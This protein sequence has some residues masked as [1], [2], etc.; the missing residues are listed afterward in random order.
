MAH[1]IGIAS[2]KGGAGKT[3]LTMGLAGAALAAGQR[4]VVLDLDPQ[5]SL[6]EWSDLRG[7]ETPVVA[8]IPVARLPKEL[9]TAHRMADLILIDTPPHSEATTMAVAKAADLILIPC[10]PG[11]LDILSIR[12]TT[13]MIVAAGKRGNIVFNGCRPN[14]KQAAEAGAAV[15]SLPANVCPKWLSLRADFD[16]AVTHGQTIQEFAPRSKAAVE[17]TAVAVWAFNSLAR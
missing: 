10:R 2:Q 16:A 4:V 9:E 7:A 11:F 6:S 17:M 12:T 13:E 1:I 3:T 5:A 8:A 15:A 14:S